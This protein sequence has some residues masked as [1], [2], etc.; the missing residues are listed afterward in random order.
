MNKRKL[1]KTGLLVSEI[2]LGCWPLGGSCIINGIPLTMGDV[3]EE[4][5]NQIINESIRLGINVFDTADFYSL[6]NSER[7]LGNAIK[8]IR[9]NIFI[10]TKAGAIPSLG[11]NKPYE[12]DISYHH[13]ISSLERSLKRMN[14]DYVDVFQCHAA[15]KTEEEFRELEKTFRDIKKSGKA[16]FCGVSTGSDHKTGLKLI[17][18]GLVDSLQ[19]YFSLLDNTPI[20]EL[21]PAAKKENVGIIVAEPMAKGFLTGKYSDVDAFKNNDYR[22][23]LSKDEIQKRIKNSNLFRKFTNNSR[24]LSQLALS[25]VLSRNEVSTCI[26]SSKSIEQLKSN[27]DATNLSLTSDELMEIKE[28]QKFFN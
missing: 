12:I 7:R 11:L 18:T 21:L 19:I 10:L 1:G 9:E 20:E 26:P 23:N 5:T 3:N 17:E 16:R 4:T 8:N 22:S 25:Y 2:G 6:G 14:V 24:T 13:L 27:V 28:I 15:P